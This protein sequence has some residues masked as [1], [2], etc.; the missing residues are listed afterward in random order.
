MTYEEADKFITKN[1]KLIGSPFYIPKMDAYGKILGLL[2]YC[3]LKNTNPNENQ[4]RHYIQHMY[5]SLLLNLTL[6]V[7]K[8]LRIKN[9]KILF[10]RIK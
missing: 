6:W 10:Q 5:V 8:Y 3:V 9:Q 7:I 1:K 2:I 4:V